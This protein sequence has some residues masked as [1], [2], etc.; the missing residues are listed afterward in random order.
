MHV[1]ETAIF[2][3]LNYFDNGHIEVS[4]NYLTYLIIM[5]M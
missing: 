3:N 2:V 5:H 1:R 4:G